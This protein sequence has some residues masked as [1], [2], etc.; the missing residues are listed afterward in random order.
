MFL[1]SASLEEGEI[2]ASQILFLAVRGFNVSGCLGHLSP[3]S[4]ETPTK[5]S[6]VVLKSSRVRYGSIGETLELREC[7]KAPPTKHW[8]RKGWKRKHSVVELIVLGMV[9]TVG[10]IE[11]GMGYRE[12]NPCT[13]IMSPHEF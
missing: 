6:A 11:S 1:H 13:R 2:A 5:S 8:I 3:R 12:A 10:M 9:T 7:P 4:P